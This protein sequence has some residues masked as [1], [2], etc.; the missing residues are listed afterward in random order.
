MVLNA[1]PQPTGINTNT[2]SEMTKNMHTAIGPDCQSQQRT[3]LLHV[4]HHPCDILPHVDAA[5]KTHHLCYSTTTY[6][7]AVQCKRL[8]QRSCV[9]A[10]LLLSSSYL[11]HACTAEHMLGSQ[12]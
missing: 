7:V 10:L 9:S 12:Q 5:L 2:V 1:H 4:L 6:G 8:L 3:L 11:V